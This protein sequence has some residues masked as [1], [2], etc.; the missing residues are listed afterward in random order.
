MRDTCKILVVKPERKRHLGDLPT[1][2]RIT[3]RLILKVFDVKAWTG[4]KW[5]RIRSS[6]WLC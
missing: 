4:F 6:D 2:G 5:L 3:L 1:G